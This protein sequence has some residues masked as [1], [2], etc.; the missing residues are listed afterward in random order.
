MYVWIWSRSW[1]TQQGNCSQCFSN[2]IGV[3]LIVQ[4]L[5][6]SF[7]VQREN[8]PVL[9]LR[10]S[11]FQLWE[12]ELS[13]HE[14]AG[15]QKVFYWILN[16]TFLIAILSLNSFKLNMVPTQQDDCAIEQL[17]NTNLSKTSSSPTYLAKDE[18]NFQFPSH[19][20]MPT[21]YYLKYMY[22]RDID[23]N[24]KE[25]NS[26]TTSNGHTGMQNN[27]IHHCSSCM[28]FNISG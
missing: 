1:G 21:N 9:P 4:L 16:L 15:C 11:N 7:Y 2:D 25:K 20:A 10:K 27:D 8:S 23:A 17:A 24:E 12:M 14:A 3:L 5:E 28:T 13:S 19:F 18:C 26:E 22:H 6:Q